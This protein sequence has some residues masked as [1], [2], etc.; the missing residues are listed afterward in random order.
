VAGKKTIGENLIALHRMGIHTVIITNS[1]K[2]SY[3]YDGTATYFMKTYPIKP[4]AKTGAGGVILNERR[5]IKFLF[6]QV[7]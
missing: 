7:L 6:N 3:A 1:T 4:I 5:Q 2:G